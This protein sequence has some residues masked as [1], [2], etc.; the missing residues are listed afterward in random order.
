MNPNLN[1][2]SESQVHCANYCILLMSILYIAKVTCLMD[3]NDLTHNDMKPFPSQ[4]PGA[5]S[6]C[7][8]SVFKLYS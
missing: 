7:S 8:A 2:T 5:S 1:I 4:Y 6:S 3:Y